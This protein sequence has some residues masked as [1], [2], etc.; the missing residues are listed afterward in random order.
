MQSAALGGGLTGEDLLTV[1]RTLAVFHSVT[2]NLSRLAEAMPALAGVAAGIGEFR[3]VEAAIQRTVNRS[4]E[5]VDQASLLLARLR[6]DERAAHD[7]LQDRLN[8]IITSPEGRRV[9][10]EPFITTRGDRFVLAVKA[11]HRGQLQGLIHDVSSTGATVFMEPL[12]IVELG[13]AWRELKLAE[14]R[15]VERVLRD[16]SALVGK[17]AEAMQE[18]LDRLAHIDLAL[19]KARLARELRGEVPE[20]L[21]PAGEEPIDV[22][23]LKEARHPLLTGDVVPISMELGAAFRSLVI[24]GP[25]TGGK[26]V[27]L[28]TIGLLA[29]MNQAGIPIPAAGGSAL[30]VFDGVYADIGDEQSIEQSLSTFSGH[31]SA[32]VEILK[33]ATPRSLVLLDE[34]GAGTDPQEGAAVARAVLSHL[35]RRGVATIVTTH[36]SELK[37]FA[38]SAPGVEN[39]NVEFDPESLAPTFRLAVGLPGRS[40]ALAIAQSLGLPPEVLAEARGALGKGL[41]EVET[42]LEEIQGQR[43]RIDEELAE[44]E[45]MRRELEEA[46]ALLEAKDQALEEKRRRSVVEYRVRVQVMAEEMKSRLRQAARRLNRLVG[47]NGRGELSRLTEEVE[48]IRKEL[49]EG[50]WATV[51]TPEQSEP[52]HA[53][54]IVRVEGVE[55]AAQV[56]SAPNAHGEVEVQAGKM[57]LRVPR[58]QVRRAG[59]AKIERGPLVVV[60]KGVSERA[61]VGDQYWVHGMRAQQAVEAVD[62]YIEKAVIAG[63]HRVRIIHGKGRGILRTAIQHSLDSNPLV[64]EFH[65]AGPDEGGEGVTI[66]EI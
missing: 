58:G 22:L 36:H 39:A 54:D 66:A 32:I 19:A 47:E 26:T 4:G 42:L 30:A 61:K 27:A 44:V 21:E 45:Q 51:A 48:S 64:G 56:L 18:S 29:L 49:R 13:N 35:T 53:G 10:Q 65:D 11:D 43:R 63:H 38:H 62:E 14:E 20:T 15:E 52:L 28:K 2:A 24:S 7:R 8:E 60:S 3:E 1:G 55:P 6:S 40:N 37:A 16:L 25:N 41:A 33:T 59:G 57:R 17:Q 46:H 31:M 23:Q 50:E 34:L 12:A 5:V 9:L